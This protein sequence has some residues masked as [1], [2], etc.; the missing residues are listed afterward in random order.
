MKLSESIAKTIEL[1][2]AVRAEQPDPNGPSPPS[3]WLKPYEMPTE[4]E[5]ALLRFLEGL[6]VAMI[7]SLLCVMY[8]G[9]GELSTTDFLARYQQMANAFHKPEWAAGQMS[10]KSRLAEHLQQGVDEFAQAGTDVDSLLV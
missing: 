10:G 7:Y 1:A 3:E 2:L 8:V 4:A 5:V 9:R 6:P